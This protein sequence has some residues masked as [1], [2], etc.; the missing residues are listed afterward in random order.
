MTNFTTTPLENQYKSQIVGELLEAT[1][2]PFNLVVNTAPGFTLTTNKIYAVIEPGTSR[3]EGIRISVIN[4]KNLTVDQRG[5]PRYSGGASTVGPHGGGAT[6]VISN[7][8]QTFED[9]SLAIESKYNSS[10]GVLT[11]AIQ[12]DDA[13][14]QIRRDGNDLKLKDGNQAEVTLSQLGSNA[15]LDERAKVSVNDTTTGYLSSKIVAGDNVVLEIINPGADETYKVSANPITGSYAVDSVGTDAYVVT[16]DPALSA[17]SDGQEFTFEPG[18][19]NT[20]PATINA[21]G[22]GAIPLVKG[23]YLPL[24]DG[25]FAKAQHSRISINVKSVTFTAGLALAATSGTLTGNWAYKSGIY[26]VK[27]SNADVRDVTLTNG[28]TTATWTGGLSA[29]ATVDAQSRYAQVLSSTG[30]SSGGYIDYG[31]G[32]DGAYTTTGNLT[33]TRDMFYT[34]LT[35]AAGHVLSTAGFRI[36]CNGTL[37]VAA[38]GTIRNNGSN[39]SNASNS[40]GDTGGVASNGGVG[41]L[42]GSM[43]AGASGGAGG[44]GGNQGLSGTAGTAGTSNTKLFHTTNGAAGGEGRQ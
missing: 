1:T 44:G 40:V 5:L 31:D 6:I 30:R 32:S 41:G 21:N 22:L 28:A 27:F 16:L 20:G 38:T 17:Y 43:K 15:G 24:E 3:E 8:W 12:F 11:G 26:S 29:A 42:G 2:A 34:N 13:T 36:F 10:G 18:A 19:P 37:T 39:A 9:I 23:D 4:G 33:L 14:V 35:V 7:N 25:D